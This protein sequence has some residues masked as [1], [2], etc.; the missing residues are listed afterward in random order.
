LWRTLLWQGPY[1]GAGGEFEEERVAEIRCDEL[2]TS[3]FPCPPVP[4][5]GRR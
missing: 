1:A 4:L 5:V 3:P 2:T